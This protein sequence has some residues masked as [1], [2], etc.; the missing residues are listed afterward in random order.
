VDKPVIAEIAEKYFKN[1][2]KN[3]LRGVTS[4][5]QTLRALLWRQT[6]PLAR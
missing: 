1:I 4:F 2:F 6:K 3:T 5:L